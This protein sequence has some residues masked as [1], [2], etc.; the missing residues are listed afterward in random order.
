MTIFFLSDYFFIRYRALG[1]TASQSRISTFF[2][3]LDLMHFFDLYHAGQL[4]FALDVSSTL[5]HLYL[6]MFSV[7]V[8]VVVDLRRYTE[9]HWSKHELM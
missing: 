5:M 8:V 1:H 2:L 3:L 9:A 4:D 7:V 6:A